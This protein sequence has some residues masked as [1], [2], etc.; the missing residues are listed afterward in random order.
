ME[1][2]IYRLIPLVMNE[3][4]AIEKGRRNEQQKY[5]FRGIDDVMAAFQPVLAKHQIFYI[6]EVLNREVAER[7][8]RSGGILIYTTLTMAYT[9]YAPDGS[10]VRSVV[11]GEAMDRGDTSSNQAMSA[12]LKY[13][14]LQIF[15][16]PTESEDADAQSHEL[17]PKEARQTVSLPENGKTEEP[18]PTLFWLL[19]REYGV[20]KEQAAV[21]ARDSANNW[22]MAIDKL[23]AMI[24]A[25]SKKIA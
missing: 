1:Q 13:A 22:K 15:C 19:Q 7:E 10:S 18:S 2:Q 5:F 9:F 17:R 25:G 16:V 3:V 8:S 24:P 21:I 12:A 20:P 14:L 11:V 4:G 6:P 23:K